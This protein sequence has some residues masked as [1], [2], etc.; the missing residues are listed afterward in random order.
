MMTTPSDPT[1]V[2][3][4]ALGFTFII[5]GLYYIIEAPLIRWCTVRSFVRKFRR[6]MRQHDHN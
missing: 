6:E 3:D 2:P 1:F 4:L 5:W